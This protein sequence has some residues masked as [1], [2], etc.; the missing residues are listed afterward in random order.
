MVCFKREFSLRD[1]V[2]L[3]ERIWASNIDNYSI[4]VAFAMLNVHRAELLKRNGF[5]EMLRFINDSS[6]HYNVDD[7]ISR[8]M[9]LHDNFKKLLLQILP[10]R[11]QIE[12]SQV[13]EHKNS[14]CFIV[15]TECTDED[16]QVLIELI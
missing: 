16:L 13:L 15:E 5:D 9:F 3:W 2:R 11:L 14:T 12:I 8:S 1:L 10:S 7:I 4:F 6:L